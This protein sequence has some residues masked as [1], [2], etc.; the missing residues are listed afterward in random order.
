MTAGRPKFN[1]AANA[2]SARVVLA[3]AEFHPSQINRKQAD[4]KENRPQRVEKNLRVYVRRGISGG[5]ERDEIGVGPLHCRLCCANSEK[6]AYARRSAGDPT[7]RCVGFFIEALDF[8]RIFWSARALHDAVGNGDSVKQR[9]RVYVRRGILR[10]KLE[11]R[12]GIA[13]CGEMRRDAL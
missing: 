10:A 13:Q 3:A 4:E 2:G 5:A 9:L 6:P 7:P 8:G 11:G 12:A 1:A